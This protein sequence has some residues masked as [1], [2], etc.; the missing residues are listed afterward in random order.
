MPKIV[1]S[2]AKY[3]A[4][5]SFAWYLGIIF[6][7]SLALMHP[8]C[9][10][11]G[12]AAISAVDA[13]FTATSA[14]C[15]TGLAVRSTATD[16]NLLGQGVILLL[17]QVGGIGIMTITSYLTLHLGRRE[18][19]GHRL[20]FAETLGAEFDTDLRWILRNVLAVTLAIEGLGFLV[21]TIRNLFD[22][23]LPI[24]LWNALFHA[25]SA[26]CNAGFALHDDSLMRYRDDVLVNLTI[27]G[28]V[29]VGGIGFPVILDVRRHWEKTRSW[30]W[31]WERLHLHSKITLIGTAVLLL[32]SS[33]CVLLLERDGVLGPVTPWKRPVVAAFHAV[34]C[35]TAGFNTV[36]LPQLT[37]ATLFVSILLM[38]IGAGACSTAGG[39]K[40]STMSILVAHAWSMFR[41]QTRLNLFRRTVSRE[42]IAKAQAMML[43]FLVVIICGLTLL[44]FLEHSRDSYAATKG[45]FMAA[46]F[47]VTSALG[48]VGLSLG[49]TP[50]L[51]VFGKIIVILL[52]FIGRLG[53]I[54]IFVALS[55]GERRATLAYPDEEPMFG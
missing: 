47:E 43:L 22:F 42:A 25:V 15:V 26:F 6:L 10:H 30:S 2:L 48:T 8:L 5:A 19:L 9:R 33:L 40:V 16:F 32:A 44:L 7:G 46:A 17:I 45:A 20:V 38:A 54:T 27:S 41:G 21:L 12:R 24:A 18:S 39:F 14:T 50:G 1:G 55:R 3:P 29:I 31:L 28:L 53:P 49:I 11:E 51:T 34:S 52:M 23:P 4:R 13:A 35:R 36:D 37:N